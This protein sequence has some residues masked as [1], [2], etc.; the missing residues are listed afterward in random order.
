[1]LTDKEVKAVEGRP[2]PHG[3]TPRGGQSENPALAMR[4]KAR[5]AYNRAEYLE[6]R[7]AMMPAWGDMVDGI[8][9][10]ENKVRPIKSARA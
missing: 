10:A 7:R 4:S 3:C 9:T 5:A 1:M 6:E 2:A 8:A